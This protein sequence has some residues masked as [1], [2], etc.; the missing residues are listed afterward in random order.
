LNL[1]IPYIAMH[2]LETDL[3]CQADDQQHGETQPTMP[4]VR[5]CGITRVAAPWSCCDIRMR[6]HGVAD[7]IGKLWKVGKQ[8]VMYPE[9]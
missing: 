2:S 5:Q 7:V 1:Q 3:N 8:S 4:N 6:S 9:P